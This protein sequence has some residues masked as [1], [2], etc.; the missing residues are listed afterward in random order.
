MINMQVDRTGLVNRIFN[1]LLIVTLF[2]ITGFLLPPLISRTIPTS[3]YYDIINPARVDKGEYFPDEVVTVALSRNS[4]ISQAAEETLELSLVQTDSD[5]DITSERRYINIEQGIRTIRLRYK[6][7][8]DL[9]AGS[10][11]I[12][13]NIHFRV[14]GI[15][16][17]ASFFT[18]EFLV[19]TSS[20]KVQ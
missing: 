7:P 19:S 8:E 5:E 20:A 15:A 6:L 14:E 13:G 1:A 17:D 18:E 3:Y 12:R 2:S 11:V 10:Y 16:R 9:K 4:R